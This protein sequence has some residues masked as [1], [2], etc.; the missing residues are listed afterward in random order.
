[1]F[2][3]IYVIYS[4]REWPSVFKQTDPGLTSR[5][6]DKVKVRAKI[7]SVKFQSNIAVI[8]CMYTVYILMIYITTNCVKGAPDE[9]NELFFS[10]FFIFFNLKNL[11]QYTLARV[12]PT[13]SFDFKL[14]V[15][16]MAKLSLK[17]VKQLE[18]AELDSQLVANPL[19]MEIS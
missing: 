1:M 11:Q 14:A 19:F 9:A 10:V 3:S 8:S 13:I 7:I 5:I 15:L 4:L 18:E 17:Y 16:F 2:V 6:Q 12:I